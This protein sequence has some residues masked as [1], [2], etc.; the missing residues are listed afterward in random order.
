MSPLHSKF[1]DFV[2]L[3]VK[4]S[5]VKL[6]K[7]DI[8]NTLYTHT[9]IKQQQFPLLEDKTNRNA[10]CKTY[11]FHL[12]SLSLSFSLSLFL[13]HFICNCHDFFLFLLLI[14][15]S[16]Y[17]KK[18]NEIHQITCDWL[19][20]ERGSDYDFMRWWCLSQSLWLYLF[21]FCV[22]VRVW[23]ETRTWSGN[24]TF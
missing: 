17:A 21:F 5:Y 12:H 15:F 19:V 7:P 18:R 10:S 13:F 4:C 22:C 20:C 9:S 8:Q 23:F 16:F 11:A 6:L 1:V 3:A 14:H 24:W 2:R